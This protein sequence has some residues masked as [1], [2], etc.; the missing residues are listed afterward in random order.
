MSRA[1][2]GYTET[3]DGETR[4]GIIKI[5]YIVDRHRA[6]LDYLFGCEG[7]L[8]PLASERGLPKAYSEEVQKILDSDPSVPGNYISW[9][10]WK[11]VSFL[12]GKTSI[13]CQYLKA[14]KTLTLNIGE[15]WQYV[16]YSM[17]FLKEDANDVRMIV[18]IE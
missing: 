14:G 15:G 10:S 17:N 5:S 6:L 9:L 13:E 2:E 7:M 4:D 1:L 8:K 18:F 16:F 11:E 3:Y 12:A